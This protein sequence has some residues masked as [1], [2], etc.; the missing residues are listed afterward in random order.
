MIQSVR[1]FV[2]HIGNFIA[3]YHYYI[4]AF[5]L[6]SYLAKYI[7]VQYV[8]YAFIASSVIVA[9]LLYAAPPIYRSFGTKNVMTVVGVAEALTLLAL[10]LAAEP[11]TAVILV[12]LQSTLSYMLFIGMDLLIEA[13]VASESV[14]GS[15]RTAHL[16]FINVA[17]F[18]A[19]LTISFLLTGD[20]YQAAFVASAIILILFL[21]YA[22]T[23]FPSVSFAERVETEGSVV[24]RFRSDSSV[25]KIT[26]AHLLLQIFF[27]WMSIYVPILLFLFEGFTWSQIGII[28]A[29][30]M[31]PYI[32]LEYPLGYIADTWLGEKELLI[33][34]YC[35]MA[36]ALFTIPFLPMQAF[37]W[38]AGVMFVSR[39]GAA[40]VEAM[41]EVHFFRHVTQKDTSIITTF[42]ELRPLGS[43]IGPGIAS[44]CLMVLTL[45]TTFAV[46]GAVMLLGVPVALSLKDSK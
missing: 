21:V 24:A 29:I 8:G 44:V 19:S 13:S 43:I 35:I 31:L 22:F 15:A 32:F 37:W 14:T 3:Q 6:S 27:S 33:A 11:W 4:V 5:I 23:F 17:V 16:T 41:T 45:P 10:A 34:G 2:L 18:V 36:L 42:R 20:Q 9:L 46:F 26:W 39:V 38:W 25:R 1:R 40:A 12:T 30:A 7:G 28:L